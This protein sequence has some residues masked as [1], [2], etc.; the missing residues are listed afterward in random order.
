[1]AKAKV[2]KLKK[3]APVKK[4]LLFDAMK[5]KTGSNAEIPETIPVFPNIEEE[6]EPTGVPKG[7][8]PNADSPMKK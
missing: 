4:K 7:M 6:A 2:E 5:D 3:K 1:M 8:T